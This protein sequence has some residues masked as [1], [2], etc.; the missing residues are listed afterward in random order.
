M[1]G[2]NIYQIA[3]SVWSMIAEASRIV[4]LSPGT[5]TGQISLSSGAVT[6]GT[7]NDKTG[8]S[9]TAGSYTVRASSSQRGTIA[10]ASGDASQTVTIAS[11]TTTR[12]SAAGSGR[13]PALAAETDGNRYL[14]TFQITGATAVTLARGNTGTTATGAAEVWE[15]F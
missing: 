3:D 10:F 1:R 8:Y 12:A 13:G 7:N 14:M 5:G 2:F 4:R 11:V 6:V 9:L 15:L